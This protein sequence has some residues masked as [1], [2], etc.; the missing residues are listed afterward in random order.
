MSV[1]DRSILHKNLTLTIYKSSD[2]SYTLTYSQII[3]LIDRAKTYL[4]TERNAKIADKVFICTCDLYLVWLIACAELGLLLIV[5]SS[6]KVSIFTQYQHIYGK[7]NHVIVPYQ[8]HF[9]FVLNEFG[10]RCIEAEIPNTYENTEC[11]DVMYAT[12][13]TK[14]TLSVSETNIQN[15]DFTKFTH[16]HNFYYQLL[17]RNGNLYKLTEQDKCMHNKVLHHGSSLGTFFL[18]TIAYCQRHYWVPE[19]LKWNEIVFK[20]QINLCLFLYYDII[21]F[22]SKFSNRS[23]DLSFLK[24][25]TLRSPGKL[26]VD[27]YISQCNAKIVSIFGT[28]LSSGPVFL[29]SVSRDNLVD[30]NKLNFGKLL[31]NFYR[32]S[33]NE[34]SNLVIETIENER[35]QTTDQ[36]NVI[37][38]E[39]YMII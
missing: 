21:S 36:F 9:H 19:H 32:V 22:R 7:I 30:Y 18:P 11:K 33:I 1:I 24:I 26:E 17:Y 12:P 35:I 5:C 31:D 8:E 14:L 20:E 10:N 29:Q 23:I 38:S 34:K 2:Y 28:T 16:T 39:F 37:N 13:K 4:L 6:H 15:F 3:N 25:Y 27:Y